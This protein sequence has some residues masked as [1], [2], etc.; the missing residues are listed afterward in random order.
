MIK[1]LLPDASVGEISEILAKRMVSPPI[2][3]E[4]FSTEV[5]RGLVGEQDR[6][7]HDSM[8]EGVQSKQRE[9][10]TFRQ[11]WAARRSLEQSGRSSSAQRTVVVIKNVAG[12]KIS[13]CRGPTDSPA[14]DA[15]MLLVPDPAKIYEDPVNHKWQGS[16]KGAGSRSRG[17]LSH[18]YFPPCDWPSAGVGRRP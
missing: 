12:R 4:L 8:V 18:G 11:T 5:C 2:K 15:A 16:W 9:V 13:H 14:K 6:K 10:Q 7:Q 17:W 3:D 1:K